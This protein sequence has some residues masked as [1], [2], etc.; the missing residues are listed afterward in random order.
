MGLSCEVL[1]GLKR[2]SQETERQR[3]GESTEDYEARM[4]GWSKRTARWFRH[5]K[6][7]IQKEHFATILNR[8]DRID[9]RMRNRR[10]AFKCVCCEDK[11][12]RAY[13]KPGKSTIHIC[14]NYPEPPDA[15][16]IT[17][18]MGHAYAKLKDYG[19]TDSENSGYTDEE[20]DEIELSTGQRVS[21][22]DTYG[23]YL[24]DYYIP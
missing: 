17:H 7:K 4:Q 23:H 13:V 12:W 10:I 15:A 5:P 6:Q 20:G 18:E 21:N 8:F 22:A 2:L 24:E 11:T 19:F 1:Q 3:E 16:L 14:T 9:T